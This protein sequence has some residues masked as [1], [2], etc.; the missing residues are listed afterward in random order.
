MCRK[1]FISIKI[2]TIEDLAY[3]LG[4]LN[5]KLQS[6]VLKGMSVKDL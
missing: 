4:Q 5:L 2:I 6:S 3:A 1:C